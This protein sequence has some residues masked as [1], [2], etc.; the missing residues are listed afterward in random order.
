[1]TLYTEEAGDEG[2]TK[3]TYGIA[4]DPDNAILYAR[5]SHAAGRSPLGCTT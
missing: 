4:V 2:A 5:Q 1:M 3:Y